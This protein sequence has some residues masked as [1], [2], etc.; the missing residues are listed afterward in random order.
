MTKYGIQLYSVR[1]VAEGDL[2]EAL[3]LVSEMGY[4]YVEFAGFFGNSAEDVKGWLE[5][6]GLSAIGTHTLLSELCEEK[7]EET[8]AF[9]KA[10]GC[11][12]II[13]P[14]ADWDTK[15]EYYANIA[16]INEAAMR[17]AEEGIRLGYHNHSFEFY[18]TP[19]GKV[20]EE[21]LIK[22]TSVDLEIDVF[23][24]ANAGI[25]PVKYLEANKERI[26]LIHL[27]DG[28]TATSE[29]T[30]E[31]SV[32]EAEGRSIGLGGVP[33]AQVRKWAIKNGVTMVV[34]SEDLN[35]SGPE[36]ARRC[37]DYLA[38]IEA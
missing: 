3:R 36:E 4:K 14:I 20:I 32:R 29:G 27:K 1:D 23:W 22:L 18:K 19:Y 12:N 21:E 30:F 7:I 38:S 37:I 13:I 15:D 2:K 5:E 34:E 35:P 26:R 25:D 11:K 6:F 9:H 28:I 24:L 31:N 10:I 17:L 16:A 8:V 33:C